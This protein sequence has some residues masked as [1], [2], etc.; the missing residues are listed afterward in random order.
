MR[1]GCG[2][3]A[4]DVREGRSASRWRTPG[5]SQPKCRYAR[6]MNRL[7]DLLPLREA[8]VTPDALED[9]ERQLRR[10][11]PE[12][13]REFL[14]TS[15]G[16]VWKHFPSIGFQ[17][18]TLED[19]RDIWALSEEDRAGPADLIDIASDGSRERF[20]L[21]PM[22]GAIVM[23][24]VAAEEPAVECAKTLTELVEKLAA[25]WVPFDLVA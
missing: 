21:D 12:D 3:V 2:T 23:L 7:A 22:S 8:G 16:S 9:A 10:R 6:D 4:A 5:G 24:D 1:F 18:L 15:N 19:A 13:H 11:L 17:I 14:L 25:G 20:C